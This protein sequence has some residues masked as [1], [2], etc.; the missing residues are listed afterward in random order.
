MLD[1]V[2]TCTSY[3]Y[4]RTRDDKGG[5]VKHRKLINPAFHTEK[6]K[7][8]LPAFGDSVT[9][10]INKWEGKVCERGSFEVDV[11]P[12]LMQML[13]L[14]LH[15]AVATKREEEDLNFSRNRPSSHY[16]FYN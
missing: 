6:L 11:W 7:L 14:V 16:V 5:W 2:W 8:M 3:K 13:Y 15:L 9:E 4:Y 10:V 1:M 12:Y